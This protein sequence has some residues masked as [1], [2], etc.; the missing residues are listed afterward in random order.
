MIYAIHN[1]WD[2]YTFGGSA[3]VGSVIV[4]RGEL[5]TKFG[6]PV[7]VNGDRIT[8]RWLFTFEDGTI[9]TIFNDKKVRHQVENE[10]FVGGF[11]QYDKKT[12]ENL[13]FRAVKQ[14]LGVA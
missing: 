5:V 6:E 9:G 7:A 1:K 4:P 12:K 11:G 13:S 3:M 14:L 10:W 8:E 2:D